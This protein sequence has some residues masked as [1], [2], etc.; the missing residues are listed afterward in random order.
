MTQRIL[1]IE[2]DRELVE[3]LRSQAPE[4]GREVDFEMDGQ[5]GLDR[6]LGSD[7]QLV[8][9]DVNLPSLSGF[10]V[11]RKLRQRKQEVAILMLTSR[12]E[13]IDRV[14]GL[15]LGADDYVTKPFSVR[16]LIARM[17][18]LLRRVEATAKMTGSGEK[19][20]LSFGELEIDITRRKVTRA[21]TRIDLTAVEFDLLAFL[22]RHPGRPF[23][24]DELMREVWGYQSTGFEPTVTMHLSRL[25]AKIEPNPENPVYIR[26]VRGVGYRFVEPG[27]LKTD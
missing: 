2:D 17:K 6:A 7:Y 4:V 16:E 15:E 14:L 23:S 10:E 3:L 20:V 25:R 19:L 21:Q 1:L 13:E 5:A 12:S 22:A 18:A 8:V 11:C 27:E 9:I 24:R 26:T